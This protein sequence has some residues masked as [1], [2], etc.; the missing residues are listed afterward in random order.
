MDFWKTIV[1]LA[2]RWHVG[3][4]VLV[5]AIAVASIAFVLV[6]ARYTA[7]AT[8]VLTTPPSGGVLSQDPNR[9]TGLT[10]PLLQFGEG[11]KTTA[12][13]LIQVMNTPDVQAG[14]GV[15]PGGS[16]SMT[17]DNG[18]SNPS[19]FGVEG[20]FVYVQSEAASAAEAHDVVVRAQQRA[21]DELVARQKALNAPPSTYIQVV[22]VVSVTAPETML[23]GKWRT[24]GIGFFA[25][26]LLGIGGAYAAQRLL[27]V[28]RGREN[29]SPD[30]EGDESAAADEQAPVDPPTVRMAPVPAPASEERDLFT[31]ASNGTAHKPVNGKETQPS[32][33]SR[34]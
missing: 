8:M 14:V 25:C 5:L 26:V 11:L 7:S 20:P 15:L 34:T 31:P 18:A 13:I 4:P 23:G 10:N 1:N 29:A 28:R 2:R 27:T 33:E 22:D 30:D 24:A 12:G 9:P 21:R 3:P 32:R 19:L 16:T 6:P 17:V